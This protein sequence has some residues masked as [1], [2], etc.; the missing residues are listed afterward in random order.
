MHRAQG[1]GHRA[2]P[3]QFFKR[4]SFPY[5]SELENKMFFRTKTRP[6]SPGAAGIRSVFTH[7]RRM[8]RS[9]GF[10]GRYTQDQDLAEADFC[11]KFYPKTD[12]NRFQLIAD[13]DDLFQVSIIY[14][15]NFNR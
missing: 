12:K 14:L 6:I 5:F 15:I 11:R 1:T 3:R 8:K 7:G 9:F 10:S 4:F 2:P 13:S